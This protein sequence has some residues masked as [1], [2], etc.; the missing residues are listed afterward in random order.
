MGDE[1]TDM[2][3]HLKASELLVKVVPQ[4]ADDTVTVIEVRIDYADSGKP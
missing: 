1:E 4:A 3:D 2:K